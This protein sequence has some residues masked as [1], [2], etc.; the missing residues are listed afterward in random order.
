MIKAVIFDC[1]G[2]VLSIDS[3]RNEAMIEYIQTL[4]PTY[5]VGMLSN[6][7]GRQALDARFRPGE[8]DQ[9]FNVVVASGDVGLEKPDQGIYELMTHQLGVKPDECLFVDDIADYCA[10]AQRLGM[11]VVHCTDVIDAIAVIQNKLG[12]AHGH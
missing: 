2:V 11:Q 1:F 5:K 8:L 9:L 6:V 3:Q 7:S 10:A 12:E 4:R